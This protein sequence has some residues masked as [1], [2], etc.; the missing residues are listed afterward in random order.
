MNNMIKIDY[1]DKFDRL[2]K[3]L[4]N[5]NITM[6]LE[7]TIDML[8][9]I[10]STSRRLI[11]DHMYDYDVHILLTEITTPNMIGLLDD[12]VIGTY[13]DIVSTMVISYSEMLLTFNL[14]QKDT[15]INTIDKL[16]VYVYQQ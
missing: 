4:V 15:F 9:V 12:D 7:E 10:L 1:P 5:K 6:S 14:H 13:H 11:I 16:G 2:N 3:L 8:D